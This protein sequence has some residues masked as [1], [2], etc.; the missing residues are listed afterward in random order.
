MKI[1]KWLWGVA[2]LS[3]MCV[4]L[5]AQEPKSEDPA[6]QAADEAGQAPAPVAADRPA[7]SSTEEPDPPEEQ[8]SA[9]NNLSF[10]VDI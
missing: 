8:V 5:V 9:D 1:R 2:L 10:P 7:P 4:T 6:A 3:L